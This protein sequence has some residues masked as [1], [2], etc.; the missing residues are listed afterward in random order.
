MAGD[1]V[2]VVLVVGAGAALK[3]TTMSGAICWLAGVLGAGTMC[4]SPGIMVVSGLPKYWMRWWRLSGSRTVGGGRRGR[5]A[6]RPVFAVP[7]DSLRKAAVL[8]RVSSVA[9]YSPE[10][11]SPGSSSSPANTTPFRRWSCFQASNSSW[12]LACPR[13]SQ[14]ASP[15]VSP[16]AISGFMILSNMNMTMFSPT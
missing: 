13:A 4:L 5:S 6:D 2:A 8:V 14:R 1:E 11:S 10:A 3:E 16:A 9:G 7:V 15:R 12:A